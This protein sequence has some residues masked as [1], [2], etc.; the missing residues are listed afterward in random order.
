MSEY[1]KLLDR[2]LEKIPKKTSSGERFEMPQANV[3]RIGSRT[4]V[5]NFNDVCSRLNRD[6]KH[7]LKYL[8]KEMA[9][10]GSLDGARAIFQG[11]FAEKSIM[12]LINT[13]STRY[14]ICPI[15]K[16][17]DTKLERKARFLFIVCEACGA[18]SSAL[19]I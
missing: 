15:C 17:P 10:A 16:R 4:I 2:A 11:K 7:V 19:N 5:Y 9:T 13:Y 18:R 8:S 6:P 14:V 1:Q 12:G 3:R